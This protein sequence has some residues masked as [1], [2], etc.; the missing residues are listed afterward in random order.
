MILE[1]I[2]DLHNVHIVVPA[3][4]AKFLTALLGNVTKDAY[5]SARESCKKDG[6]EIKEIDAAAIVH[7]AIFTLEGFTSLVRKEVPSA[8]QENAGFIQ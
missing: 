4:Q 1:R 8:T 3:I 6:M 2:D 7:Q 5:D